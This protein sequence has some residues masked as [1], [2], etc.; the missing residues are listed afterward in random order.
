MTRPCIIAGCPRLA[1][2]G[3]R[4]PNHE[5][6]HQQQRNQRRTWYHGDWATRAAAARQAWIETHGLTC[7]GLGD[8]PHPVAHATH[9]ELDHTTGKVLCHLHNVRAGP[10]PHHNPK[11]S[12]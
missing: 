7:P 8:G 5:H 2:T 1:T 6:Q 12:P 9:L 11:P 3:P 10:A 4:C